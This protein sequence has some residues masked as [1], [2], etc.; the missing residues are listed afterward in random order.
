MVE[1]QKVARAD[2]MDF[3]LRGK[4]DKDYAERL[5]LIEALKHGNIYEVFA[6]SPN[7]KIDDFRHYF[8]S[9]AMKL[10]GQVV[11]DTEVK[12]MEATYHEPD[13]NQFYPQQR[14]LVLSKEDREF[15]MKA[16]LDFLSGGFSKDSGTQRPQQP[17]GAGA[18]A[19]GTLLKGKAQTFKAE[20]TGDTG[21]ATQEELQ[22]MAQGTVDEWNQFVQD[23]WGQIFDSQMMADYEK[24]MGEIKNE[25][26][27]ILAL[28]K[29]GAI[30]PEFAL[31][32]LAKVN[33]T[34]NGCLFTWLGKKAFHVNETMNNVYNDLKKMST[35]DPSYYGSL[36]N[37]QS[38]TR[39][40]AFQMQLLQTDMQKVMSDISSVMEFVHS[41]MNE[42]ARTR[43]EII[44]KV[45]AQ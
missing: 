34:K 21:G 31:I 41:A 40:G 6:K 8:A 29:Q 24:R 12:A 23:S 9:Q 27:R 20:D 32:A 25:V 2:D 19:G 4:E 30:E 7:F 44:T 36:M 17:E 33:A 13:H 16:M 26:Q 22:S 14:G 11:Q 38:T 18:G 10:K 43:R 28:V 37:A 45:A 3:R 1:V 42:F 35:T 15:Y 39:D 5:Q